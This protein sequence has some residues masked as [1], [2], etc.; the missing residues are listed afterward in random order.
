MPQASHVPDRIFHQP[1]SF[2]SFTYEA[3]CY[4][5]R[6]NIPKKIKTVTL[7]RCSRNFQ[8]FPVC[9]FFFSPFFFLY[10]FGSISDFFVIK[11]GTSNSGMGG[12]SW[13]KDQWKFK[14]GWEVGMMDTDTAC[15]RQ[16]VM[17][18]AKYSNDNKVWEE[19]AEWEGRQTEERRRGLFSPRLLAAL[20]ILSWNVDV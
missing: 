3:R 15:A 9:V 19:K 16:Q 12:K 17:L 10:F 14:S 8:L 5:I 2:R 4:L 6:A 11:R 13:W 20:T 18:R 7:R 1:Y